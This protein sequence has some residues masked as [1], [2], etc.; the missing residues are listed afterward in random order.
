MAT[1]GFMERG[2]G[3]SAVGGRR[4][5]MPPTPSGDWVAVAR[6]SSA[7][8]PRWLPAWPSRGPQATRTTRVVN[9][10]R[11]NPINATPASRRR[12]GMA[13]VGDLKSPGG[14]PPCGFE[15]HRRYSR[16]HYPSRSDVVRLER[17]LRFSRVGCPSHHPATEYRRRDRRAGPSEAR[18]WPRNLGNNRRRRFGDSSPGSDSVS[19]DWPR[20]PWDFI[21]A[22]RRRVPGPWLHPRA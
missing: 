6:W 7:I 8:L 13:D 12:D 17:Y 5:I 9:P 19:R 10:Y 2:T 21:M 20:S 22:P 11:I 4:C 1:T 18:S 14:L 3:L 15:S 16:L